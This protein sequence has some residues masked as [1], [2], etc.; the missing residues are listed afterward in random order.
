MATVICIELDAWLAP[1]D[2]FGNDTTFGK[3]IVDFLYGHVFREGCDINS[4]ILALSGLAAGF[5]FLGADCPTTVL[6][7]NAP[8]YQLHIINRVW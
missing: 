7:R 5:R 3:Y 8:W 1:I 2:F 6:L 4:R